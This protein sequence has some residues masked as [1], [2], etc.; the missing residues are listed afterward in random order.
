M[1]SGGRWVFHCEQWLSKHRGDGHIERELHLSV[2]PHAHFNA[3]SE[4]EVNVFTSDLRGAGTDAKV[5]L[6]IHGSKGSSPPIDLGDSIA[7]FEQG[8]HD[9]FQGVSVP[10]PLGM[11]EALA[12]THD[13]T[14]PYP[15]W[16]LEKVQLKN[17]LTA[18]EY[19]CPCDRWEW[20][21]L[22]KQVGGYMLGL[23]V[24]KK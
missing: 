23:K 20:V 3:D 13:G 16:H 15:A 10:G 6:Q 11:V 17:H 22:E 5:T 8:E 14:G 2:P 1:K 21:W 24:G 9:T 12:V 19:T 7:N 4:W 18:E